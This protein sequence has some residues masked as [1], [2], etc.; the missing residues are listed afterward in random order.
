MVS[1]IFVGF[2]FFSEIRRCLRLSKARRRCDNL[3]IMPKTTSILL[4]PI[5]KLGNY[6]DTQMG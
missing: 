6:I 5:K 4:L 3:F 2:L 1:E